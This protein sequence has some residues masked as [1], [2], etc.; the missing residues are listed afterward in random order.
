M[1]FASFNMII[2]ITTAA[3]R[4]LLRKLLQ[5]VFIMDIRKMKSSKSLTT[6]CTYRIHSN[7]YDHTLHAYESIKVEIQSTL[8][9]HSLYL[10]E[11]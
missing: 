9:N 7:S 3:S 8:T 10:L 5:H 11:L 2:P 6:E 1:L 4:S